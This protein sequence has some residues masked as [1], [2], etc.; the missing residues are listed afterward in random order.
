MPEDDVECNLLQ[1]FL[2]TLTCIR[3]QILLASIIRQLYLKYCKQ[4]NDRLF[5]ENLFKD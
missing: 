1:S 4:T 5:E 3:K 2:L